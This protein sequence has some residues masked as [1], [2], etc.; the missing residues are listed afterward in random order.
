MDREDGVKLLEEIALL[1]EIKGE[2]PFKIRAYANAARALEQMEETLELH[3]REGT[4]RDVTG[5]GEAI[6]KKIEIFA[7]EGNLPYLEELKKEIPSGLLELIEIPGLGGKKIGKLHKELKVESLADLEVAIEDGRVEGMSGFGKKSADKL[8]VAIAN[9]KNYGRRRLWAEVEGIVESILEGLRSLPGVDRAEAAGSYRRKLETVGDLDF[10]VGSAEPDPVMDWF[11]GLPEISEV[12]ARGSTKSSVRLK[13]GLQADLRVVPVDR[14]VFA[15]H[16]FTGSKDHNVAMRQLA[17]GKGYRLSEWGLFAKGKASD[18]AGTE[19]VIAAADEKDLFNALGLAFIPA[20]HREGRGEI[21]AARQ[22][23]L[24]KVIGPEELR[25]AF[26]NHTTA[27]DGRNTLEEMAEAAAKL[28]W[29]YLGI[30]DHSKASFQANGL[31]EERLGKQVKAI[32][33]WNAGGGRGIHLFA[34]VECDILKDGSL[35]LSDAALANLDYVVGSIHGSFGLSEEE[36]TA[37]LIRAIEHPAMTMIGHLTGRILL[38]REGYRIDL[39]KVFEAAAANGVLIEINANPS[40]LDMDWRHW[41]RARELGVLAVINP[42]AHSREGLAEVRFGINVAQ[43]GWLRKQDI[44]NTL[45]LDGMKDW[46]RE[47]KR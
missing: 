25:G 11:V 5:V 27:S 26:H 42:D 31:D 12:T 24:E 38:R 18:D 14:F 6:A 45:P 43:K 4:L 8:R 36:Q 46:L 1:L 21:E 16:H 23:D 44:L 9:R 22:G 15:L 13:D 34:G 33:E 10:L 17:I 30:A 32:R 19:P 28:G 20:T 29:E 40:R 3:L 39:K 47:K 35:D 37:R 2:N 41:Q 7:R